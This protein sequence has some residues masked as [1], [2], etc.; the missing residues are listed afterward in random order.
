MGGY[1]PGDA[2][3]WPLHLWGRLE[4]RG[5]DAEGVCGKTGLAGGGRDE[6]LINVNEFC[7]ENG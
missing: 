1:E 2:E 5:P 3:N 4:H 7:T 6:S